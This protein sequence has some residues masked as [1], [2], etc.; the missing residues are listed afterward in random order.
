[1]VA[2]PIQLDRPNNTFAKTS[3]AKTGWVKFSG[4]PNNVARI[5]KDRN[6]RLP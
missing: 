3:A 1:M 2:P 4:P 5:A 6:D